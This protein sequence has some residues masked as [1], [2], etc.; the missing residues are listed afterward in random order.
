MFVLMFVY[1]SFNYEILYVS[2]LLLPELI[3]LVEKLSYRCFSVGL[4]PPV[5]T[6]LVCL[7]NLYIRYVKLTVVYTYLPNYVPA[8]LMACQTIRPIDLKIGTHIQFDAGSNV[9]NIK[10]PGGG[11]GGNPKVAG[12]NKLDFYMLK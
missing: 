8:W 12:P 4:Q 10:T 1:C 3:Q 5:V 2:R 11:G 7:L 9:V 6:I